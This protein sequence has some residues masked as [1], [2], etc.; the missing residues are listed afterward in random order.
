[1]RI[2]LGLLAV[3]LLGAGGSS[4]TAPSPQT[5]SYQ[6]R[7]VDV[8][9]VG[10]RAD[11]H[12]Q[13]EAVTRQGGATVWTVPKEAAARLL[14][15]ASGDPKTT[16]L[17]APKVTA[18]AG[19]PAHVSTRTNRAYVADVER[20]ADGPVNHASYVAY[21]PKY[22]TARE[23]LTA[24]VS[25]RKLDQGVLAQ[26]VLE[27]TRVNSLHV[28]RLSEVQ[29]P[30]QG[31][32]GWETGVKIEVPEL[33]RCEVAG[34]WLIPNDGALLISLGAFTAAD[35]DGKATVR[36]RLA[37][38]EAECVALPVTP[39][40]AAAMNDLQLPRPVAA[41]YATTMSAPVAPPVTWLPNTLPK[42][43]LPVPSRSLPQPMN[44]DGHEVSLPPL[45]E[46]HAPPTAMPGSS[47]PCATPQTRGQRPAFEPVPEA[48]SSTPALMDPQT[49][50][51]SYDVEAPV[52]TLGA[53]CCENHAD[54]AAAPVAFEAFPNRAYS[55]IA[56]A[57]DHVK[58]EF[59]NRRPD[60]ENIIKAFK[61]SL[62]PAFD[63]TVEI[64][65]PPSTST[66]TSVKRAAGWQAADPKATR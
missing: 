43:A 60:G 36:E 53:K 45:P 33:N 58:L 47:D 29:E 35:Q 50:M 41:G 10:W 5:L 55:D 14:K 8:R 7:L 49:S 19:Q 52:C 12:S 1:M 22:E 13:M 3:S 28:V 63:V 38:I 48:R 37:L 44:A 16:V 66:S 32:K 65:T 54:A 26:V 30:S 46:E 18:F 23:G 64:R 25:G 57:M 21:S 4:E 2:A 17:M 27:D 24:T 51:A 34:E 15:T 42:I 11:V 39:K 40:A 20:H 9:G 59:D 61:F 56:T 62:P 31:R 6:I